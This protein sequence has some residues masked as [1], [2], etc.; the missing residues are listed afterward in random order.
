M[1]YFSSFAPVAKGEGVDGPIVLRSPYVQTVLRST[2]VQ[3]ILV[4][5]RKKEDPPDPL[6]IP[7]L[8]NMS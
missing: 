5:T 4:K 2:Y 1:S 8:N 7:I 3:S 6:T